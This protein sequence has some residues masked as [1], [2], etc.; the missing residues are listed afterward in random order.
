MFIYL[1]TYETDTVIF[2]QCTPFRPCIWPC[3]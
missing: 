2:I 3:V 1:I